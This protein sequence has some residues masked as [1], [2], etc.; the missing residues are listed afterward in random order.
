[1]FDLK[2]Q[3]FK[4]GLT[5]ASHHCE[6][7]GNPYSWH[8]NSKYIDYPNIKELFLSLQSETT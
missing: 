8:K 3:D 7:R 1:M 2:I 4:M 6:E 5:A